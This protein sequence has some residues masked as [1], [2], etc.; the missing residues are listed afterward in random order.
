MPAPR[1]R[2][3]RATPAPPKPK[4]ACSPRHAR[5]TPAPLSCSP[6]SLERARLGSGQKH[7]CFGV[8]CRG[9]RKLTSP[10]LAPSA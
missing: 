5:A 9:R 3:A 8:C 6:W 7:R 1:P 2:H 4:M 10:K